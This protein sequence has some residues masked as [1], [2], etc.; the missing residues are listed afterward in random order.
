MA[1]TLTEIQKVIDGIVKPE[2]VSL[3]DLVQI[4]STRHIHFFHN[5]IKETD[6]DTLA[7]SYKQKMT[8]LG[9][10]II[11]QN[12]SIAKNILFNMIVTIGNTINYIDLENYTSNNWESLV[13]NNIVQG[14]EIVANIT[15]A[16]RTAY[17]A[18]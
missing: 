9:K 10:N 4:A 2:D 3:K 12:E 15:I 17:N 13:T 5:E 6:P 14:I 16:E 8:N 11:I 7:D 1:L 18:L